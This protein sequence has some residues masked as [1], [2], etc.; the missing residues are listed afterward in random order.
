MEEAV[1]VA[2]EGSNLRAK[3]SSSSRV[4]KV[5][6]ATLGGGAAAAGEDVVAPPTE[7]AGHKTLDGPRRARRT[8][9]GAASRPPTNRTHRQCCVQEQMPRS[10]RGC[11]RSSETDFCTPTIGL[12]LLRTCVREVLPYC[13]RPCRKGLDRGAV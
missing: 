2:A 3:A 4:N 8:S 12:R 10:W 11:A 6:K 5:N 9:W 7:A 1:A 13:L